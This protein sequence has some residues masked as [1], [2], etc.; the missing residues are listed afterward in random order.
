M[1]IVLF[2]LIATFVYLLSFSEVRNIPITKTLD[3]FPYLLG[4]WRGAS[5]TLSDES[6]NILGVDHYMQTTVHEYK[7]KRDKSGKFK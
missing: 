2:L 7:A 4:D 6:L 5:G 1:G 3:S